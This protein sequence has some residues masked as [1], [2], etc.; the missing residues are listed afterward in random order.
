VLLG[1]SW[2]GT[3]YSWSSLIII[4]LLVG[5]MALFGVFML[6]EIYWVPLPI[7]PFRLFIIRN[8]A[9]AIAA[10]FFL[11]FG[12]FAAIFYLPV[13]FQYVLGQ[14]ATVS[15]LQL[16][17]MMFGII[18]ASGISGFLVTKFGHYYSYPIIGSILSALG[19]FLLDLLRPDSSQGLISVILLILGTGVGLQMQIIMLIAQNAVEPVDIAVVTT[20]LTFFRTMGGV[21]GLTV[22]STILQNETSILLKKAMESGDPVNI[23]KVNSDAIDLMFLYLAPFVAISFFMVVAFKVQPLRKTIGKPAEPSEPAM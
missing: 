5:G 16:I 18:L 11:G 6:V 4:L 21:F 3:T 19:M 1:V 22:A 2:G 13:W 10:S 9:L 7:M 8:V 12:M 15:G 20:T 17:P 14:S 23:N